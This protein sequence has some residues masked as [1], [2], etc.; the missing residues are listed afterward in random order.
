MVPWKAVN[1]RLRELYVTYWY[2]VPVFLWKQS[3]RGFLCTASGCGCLLMQLSVIDK[4]SWQRSSCWNGSQ[5]WGS[6]ASGWNG[7]EPCVVSCRSAI[8]AV[9]FSLLNW[10]SL[11]VILQ[12]WEFSYPQEQIAGI[13][14]W[15]K[16]ILKVSGLW[17]GFAYSAYKALPST[18]SVYRSSSQHRFSFSAYTFWFNI[19]ILTVCSSVV[20]SFILSHHPPF[21]CSW[22]LFIAHTS[23]FG[24][25]KSA[26]NLS[27][28]L[29]CFIFTLS[30][31]A[32]HFLFPSLWQKWVKW[33]VNWGIMWLP[34]QDSDRVIQQAECYYALLT[35]RD[36]IQLLADS[37]LAEWKSGENF[38]IHT[39]SIK[40]SL[41][42]G[43]LE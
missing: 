17:D 11:T 43:I 1:S 25:T 32:S 6:Q 20:C 29:T 37:T 23:V 7:I 41:A 10:L 12:S 18:F 4:L 40:A 8:K 35:L 26:Y 5:D 39:P 15:E 24:L 9:K 31:P 16:N 3:I 28:S 22:V 38:S 42:N 13:C 36:F 34:W 33:R 21:H 27:H 19:L 14:M 2:R 30:C